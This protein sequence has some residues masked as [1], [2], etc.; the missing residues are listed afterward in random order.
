MDVSHF[1]GSVFL[2]LWKLPLGVLLLLF[3]V[4]SFCHALTTSLV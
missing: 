1:A 4:I 3:G 2:V